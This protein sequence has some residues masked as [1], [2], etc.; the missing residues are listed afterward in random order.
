MFRPSF[1]IL[2]LS[3]VL[4][5]VAVVTG[6]AKKD[7]PKVSGGLETTPVEMGPGNL[8]WILGKWSG[9]VGT[10][11]AEEDWTI[12]KDRVYTGVGRTIIDGRVAYTE[13]FRIDTL[14]NGNM[15]YLATPQGQ[16]TTVFEAVSYG[17]DGMRFEN[18][19]HDFPQVIEYKYDGGA[20]VD[21]YLEGVE[22][23]KPRKVSYFLKR[24]PY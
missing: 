12:D 24:I 17:M 4:P 9:P 22:N 2:A 3:M 18:R 16:P 15:A 8:N 13:V 7:A 23:G 10:A 1:R 20:R 11:I 21:V 6:C 14:E 5:A 19:K